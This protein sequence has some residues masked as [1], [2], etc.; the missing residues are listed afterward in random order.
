MHPGCSHSN[1]QILEMRYSLFLLVFLALNVAARA[2]SAYEIIAPVFP[3]NKSD[4]RSYIDDFNLDGIDDVLGYS[5]SPGEVYRVYLGES[6]SFS[7]LTPATPL[8]GEG[9]FLHSILDLNKDWY[10]DLVF[11]NNA[12]DTLFL[13]T[14]VNGVDFVVC[15]AILPPH[16]LGFP[17]SQYRG[18]RIVDLNDDGILDLLVFRFASGV[19]TCTM[20]SGGLSNGC[21]NFDFD[22]A[23]I[24]VSTAGE[25]GAIKHVD[26]DGDFDL[27]LLLGKGTNQYSATVPETYINQGNGVLSGPVANGMTATRH[28]G[29]GTAGYFTDD[30]AVDFVSGAADCCTSQGRFIYK[31]TDAPG[32]F[33]Q[34]NNALPIYLNPYYSAATVCDMNL[35]GREDVL[36]TD[37]TAIGS[38]RLQ[39]HE[40]LSDE[41]FIQ[42][43]QGYNL[44][45][46]LASGGCCPI[47]RGNH[48]RIIDLN[49]DA[50]PDVVVNTY[51]FNY[52]VAPQTVNVQ[53]VNNLESNSVRI[54][55]RGCTS[56]STGY[57]AKVRVL[58][59]GVWRTKGMLSETH[60]LG[61]D[62]SIYIG[63]GAA[64]SVDSIVVEW[65]EGVV[66]YHQGVVAGT[67]LTLYESPACMAS[68]PFIPGC[69][70]ETACNYSSSANSNDGTCIYPV[71]ASDCNA[72]GESCAS[73]EVWVASIQECIQG[74]LYD[75]NADGCV[76]MLDFV[77]FLA[78]YGSCTNLPLVLI[79]ECAGCPPV[80][81]F[82][83]N[84]DMCVTSEDLIQ[85]LA[86]FQA[87]FDN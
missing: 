81:H 22:S 78:F 59:N 10:P 60:S 45:H 8:P 28:G 20:A 80:A 42:N 37:M 26:V 68:G 52:S 62:P 49:A 55:L 44:H 43:A 21:L 47:L 35:D 76:T 66:S 46:G 15:P 7:E 34:I 87:C 77:E 2:Q 73:G 9:R 19:T 61:A 85:I 6:G 14:N 67:S 65:D 24:V 5:I 25:V 54:R 82:D 53:L 41:T 27:D 16:S 39:L 18:S 48:A 31:S 4:F 17:V 23:M 70:D 1:H 12:Q 72:G 38:A 71:V 63:L 86:V 51:R 58:V 69:T 32:Q 29:F 30:D 75:I 40:Q 36:W 13:Y 33:T 84:G 83:G 64:T 11:S 74:S 50:K 56:S 3:F 79:P 57:G